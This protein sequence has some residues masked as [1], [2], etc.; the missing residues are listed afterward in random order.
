VQ[1]KSSRKRGDELKIVE[2]YETTSYLEVNTYVG[3]GWVYLMNGRKYDSETEALTIY[4]S[5]GRPENVSMER[6]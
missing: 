1:V 3:L 4:Y 6:W 5:L 2:V